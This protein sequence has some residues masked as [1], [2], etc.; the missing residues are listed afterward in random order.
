[1][2]KRSIMIIALLAALVAALR[3]PLFA[4]QNKSVSSVGPA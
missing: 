4:Q 3:L 2:V 1:M